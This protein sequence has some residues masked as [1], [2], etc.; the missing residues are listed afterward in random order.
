MQFLFGIDAMAN[1]KAV[2][3]GL[4]EAAWKPLE[5]PARYEVRTGLRRRPENVKEQIVVEKQYQNIRLKSEDVAEL[6]Y[7]P[8]ACE[9]SYRLVVVRKNL[10]VEKGERVLFDDIRYFFYITNL[11]AEEA[12]EIVFLANDRCNQENLIAQ[13]KGGVKA[14]KMPAGDLASNWAYMVMASLGWTLKAWLALMLPVKAGRWKEKHA[15]QKEG[16]LRMEFRQFVNGFMRLPCQIVKQGRKIV[17][18]L[19]SWNP[20]QEVLLRAVEALRPMRC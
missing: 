14:M 1:L 3:D 7:R 13:L 16:V 2:A 6:E 10:S 18:R 19:L 17:Y 15:K 5:R 11:R 12:D 20:W 9:K 8:T 4:P